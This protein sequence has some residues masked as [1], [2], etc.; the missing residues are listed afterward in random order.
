MEALLN[1]FKQSNS[2][3]TVINNDGKLEFVSPSVKKILGYS[4][5]EL[6]GRIWTE[7][8]LFSNE[9]NPHLFRFSQTMENEQVYLPIEKTIRDA[10]GKSRY[11][12]WSVSQL[13]STKLLVIGQD[14]TIA[15]EKE[16][17]II[18]ANKTLQLR[19]QDFSDSVDY[20]QRI[21]EA[22]LPNPDRLSRL[23]GNGFVLYKPKD[24]VSGD[25]YWFTEDKDSIY[26]VAGD[27]TGHGIPGAMLTV[28]AINLLREII[29][30][31]GVSS[32][33]EILNTLDQ[34]VIQ[35]FRD[36]NG[37][38]K[39][40]DGMDI[41]LLKLSKTESKLKYAAAFRPV[42][43]VRNGVYQELK[44]ERYPI[45]FFDEIPKSFKTHTLE[46]EDQ[47]S[48][49][50]FSDGYIDQ[51]G[52]ERDKKFSKAKFRQLI[53]SIQDLEIEEQGGFLDYAFRNWKQDTPQTDDV[54]LMGFR[55]EK[56]FF[57]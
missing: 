26:I 36:D 11:F 3:I 14:I 13:D 23:V 19:Q 21:Q 33:G 8:T 42:G 54:V 5:Q 37:H 18:E 41:V 24:T 7:T 28:L 51:F 6:T 25:F 50:L 53:E 38:Y 47:D 29:Q 44:G 4:A 1:V 22:I 45:G 40:K 57:G 46:L 56:D 39:A 35:A 48:I 32:P 52:G 2:I 20:A 16:L 9:S 30:K 43:L 10:F 27:C 34:E 17:S 49:Y 15:K 12:L 55:Y 31:Q